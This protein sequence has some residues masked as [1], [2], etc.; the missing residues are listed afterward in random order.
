ML[1]SG[2]CVPRE[3]GVEQGSSKKTPEPFISPRKQRQDVAPGRT[4][5]LPPTFP[6]GL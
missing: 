5:V 4:A 6:S 1:R 3:N 2:A